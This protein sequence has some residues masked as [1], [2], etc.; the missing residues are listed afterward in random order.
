MNCK[1]CGDKIVWRKKTFKEIFVSCR[2][3]HNFLAYLY[4]EVVLLHLSRKI[5][6]FSFPSWFFCNWLIEW[7][8]S[9]VWMLAQRFKLIAV[10][11]R[12][13]LKTSDF[14]MSCVGL[15]NI[16]QYND[17]HYYETSEPIV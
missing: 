12:P 17:S 14:I 6:C 1:A 10:I 5:I 7:T 9:Y 8:A 3:V 4:F 13:H 16:I 15:F 2:I 11:A